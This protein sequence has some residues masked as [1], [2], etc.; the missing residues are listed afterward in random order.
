MGIGKPA[1]SSSGMNV[2]I[3]LE[4]FVK[5]FTALKT[6]EVMKNERVL[7]TILEQAVKASGPVAHDSSG[8]LKL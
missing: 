7:I 5:M 1:G 6:L 4:N 2:Q 8:L 3:Y